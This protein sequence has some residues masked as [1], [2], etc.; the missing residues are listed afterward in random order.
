MR[1]TITKGAVA[2]ALIGLAQ[3]A[4]ADSAETKGG[5]KIKTDDGRFEASIRGRNP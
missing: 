3:P 2:A 5:I 1:N 4:L